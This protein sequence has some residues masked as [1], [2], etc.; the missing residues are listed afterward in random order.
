MALITSADQL[1]FTRP[2]LD[3]VR[4][5]CCRREFRLEALETNPGFLCNGCLRRK[6]A[7]AAP[8]TLTSSNPPA[9]KTGLSGATTPVVASKPNMRKEVGICKGTCGSRFSLATLTKYKHNGKETGM[10][11]KCTEKFVAER[12]YARCANCLE[13]HQ[14]E[15][16]VFGRCVNCRVQEQVS[17]PCSCGKEV[18]YH[19]ADCM[20]E[21]LYNQSLELTMAKAGIKERDEMID[22]RDVKLAKMEDERETLMKIIKMLLNKQ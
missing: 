17:I 16:V 19:H 8:T 11:K 3:W 21:T 5:P 14:V 13:E 12:G 22:E 6:E 9:F 10:C 4:C 2:P 1:E 20:F 18:D 7:E 15:H